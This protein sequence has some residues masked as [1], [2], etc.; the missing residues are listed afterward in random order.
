VI[1]VKKVIKI[2]IL[3]TEN[4]KTGTSEEMPE[5]PNWLK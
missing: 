1:K 4:Q 5:F 3:C 2:V